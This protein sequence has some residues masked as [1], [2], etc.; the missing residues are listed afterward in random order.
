MARSNITILIGLLLAKSAWAQNLVENDKREVE[1][2]A[3]SLL[4]KEDLAILLPGSKVT[5]RTPEGANRYWKNSPDGKFVV[6]TDAGDQAGLGMVRSAKG[7]WR[8]GDEGTYCVTMKW[9]DTLEQW[10]RY[11][12]KNGDKYLGL[13]SKVGSKVDVHEFFFSR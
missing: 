7:S 12:F 11:L 2:A 1:F 5:Q 10:C 3:E 8:I 13:E 4:S 9:G 6:S